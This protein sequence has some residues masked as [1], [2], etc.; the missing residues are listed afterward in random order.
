MKSATLLLFCVAALHGVVAASGLSYPIVGTGQTTC[1]GATGPLEAPSAGEPFHGQDAQQTAPAPR[2]RDNGDGT[3]SDLVTGL[4]WQRDPGEKRTFAEAEAAV[5]TCRLGGHDDWRLPTIKELYSLILFT[6]E[7]MGEQTL[8]PYLDTRYFVQPK[9]AEGEREIDVQTWSA[10]PTPNPVMGNQAAYFG[11][12]FADGRIKGYPLMRQGQANRLFFRFV[13]GNPDYGR[14]R[15]FDNGDGTISDFA[16]GLMWQ[17]ADAGRRMDWEDALAYAEGLTLAGHDDWHLPDAKQLQSIVDYTRSPA[18]HPLFEGTLCELDEGVR[19]VPYY[20]S[21]TTHL[22]GRPRGSRA[23]YV[24]LG[25]AWGKNPRSGERTDVH[26]CGAQ[27]S[28]PKTAPGPEASRY[29]GPQKDLICGL[30]GVRCVRRMS[31]E[32]IP[33]NWQFAV[34]GDMHVPTATVTQALVND[35]LTR[36]ADVVLFPG[37]LVDSG[38]RTSVEDLEKELGLWRAVVAPLEAAGIR[39]LAVRGNHEADVAG[40][41]AIWSRFFGTGLNHTALFR[42]V[43][44]VGLD[45]YAQGERTVDVAWLEQALRELPP[46][47]AHVVPYGHEPAFSCNT[48][49]PRCLDANPEMRDRFW[50]LLERVRASWYFCGH[51]HRMSRARVVSP[52]GHTITQVVSG[53]GGGSL[54]G[55]SR[56]GA[57]AEATASKGY[58]LTPEAEAT[59]YGYTLVT[60]TPKA[61]QPLWIPLAETSSAISSERP[62]S[63]RENGAGRERPRR[64]PRVYG[65]D[66]GRASGPLHEGRPRR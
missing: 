33:E 27:R 41:A 4:M 35:L 60:V 47:V 58:A 19:D 23:V 6:G 42:N 15:F 5:K 22:D 59:A 36:D 11:V 38:R 12:N 46:T 40:S 30:N 57:T 55:A 7:S 24:C 62:I 51:A 63:E 8:R 43:C 39:L 44:F 1:Y 9:A 52:S 18:L 53:G 56:N 16:T 25:H 61:L 64:R 32:E 2:Y 37:D 31:P 3:V 29:F 14:N 49:H 26:G 65:R 66:G 45:N 28:D 21:S 10:T 54:H 17:K 50:E 13:R 48:Y 20:W 34:V